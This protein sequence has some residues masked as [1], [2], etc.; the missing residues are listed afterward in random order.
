MDS[1]YI[2]NIWLIHEYGRAD[3]I[4]VQL[5]GIDNTCLEQDENNESHDPTSDDTYESEQGS[6]TDSTTQESEKE[7]GE[8]EKY[9]VEVEVLHF[10][11][12]LYLPVE[13][14]PPGEMVSGSHSH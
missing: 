12:D 14:P 3:R 2:D 13:Q 9:L 7:S 11:D 4:A 6:V 5:R 10:P 1:P 8:C